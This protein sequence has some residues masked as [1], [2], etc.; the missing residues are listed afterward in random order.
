MSDKV[1]WRE[2]YAAAR[3]WVTKNSRRNEISFPPI[4]GQIKWLRGK[5]GFWCVGNHRM[6]SH[7]IRTVLFKLHLNGII[8]VEENIHTWNHLTFQRGN[9]F[10]LKMGKI[11]APVN[12][13]E[14]WENYGPDVHELPS[15]ESTPGVWLHHSNSIPKVVSPDGT[16]YPVEGHPIG[17]FR[18]EVVKEGWSPGKE[19]LVGHYHLVRSSQGVW[20]RNLLASGLASPEKTLEEQFFLISHLREGPT[21]LFFDGKLYVVR[22]A[23]GGWWILGSFGMPE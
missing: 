8:S 19:E 9:P 21:Y 18:N 20:C 16:S 12:H 10:I 3:W 4:R 14:V 22:E 23:T 15:W 7:S 2:A 5:D 13:S 6:D 1:N 11:P 17:V